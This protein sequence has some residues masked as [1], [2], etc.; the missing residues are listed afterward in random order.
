MR[1]LRS[2]ILCR[3]YKSPSDKIVPRVCTHAKRSHTHV[4]DPVVRVSGG[5][6]WTHQNSPVRTKSVSLQSVEVGHSKE[7][8]EEDSPND[9]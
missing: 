1:F 5:G 2:Q 4:K 6:L 7:E 3:F 8:E 9:N